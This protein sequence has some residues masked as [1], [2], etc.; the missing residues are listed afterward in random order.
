MSR[1]RITALKLLGIMALPAIA[2][3]ILDP[4]ANYLT[5]K[6][7]DRASSLNSTRQTLVAMVAG[8]AASAGLAF[9]ARTYYLSRRG[10]VT[11]RFAK[12]ISL[13][14]SDKVTERVGGVYALEQVMHESS[15]DSQM[16]T[17]LLAAFVR[18][19]RPIPESHPG[20][21]DDVDPIGL[22]ALAA[23]KVLTRPSKE[24]R[25]KIDLK[26]TD[27]RALDLQNADFSN[28]DLSRAW[29]DEAHLSDACFEGAI[30]TRTHFEGAKLPRAKFQHAFALLA[31]FHHASLAETDF[32]A[33]QVGGSCFCEANLVGANFLS[34]NLSGSHLTD[35]NLNS[36]EFCSPSGSAPATG[37]TAEQLLTAKLHDSTQVPMRL[38]ARLVCG[39]VGCVAQWVRP[40]SLARS[41]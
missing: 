4:A 28:A 31:N 30:L 25:E 32:R 13:L 8:A 40:M 22:D 36:T 14:S 11:D 2:W 7:K 26:E 33:S 1:R 6:D 12:A 19:K 37:L 5:P 9:T 21:I 38:R 39:L 18:E 29:L 41:M 20:A 35:A 27:L 24:T 17:H 15:S 16:I 10:H 23:L 34:A 3:F